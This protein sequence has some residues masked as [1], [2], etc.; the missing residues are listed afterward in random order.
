MCGVFLRVLGIGWLG[1]GGTRS[2]CTVRVIH[3][4]LYFWTNT[5]GM[6]H[7][8][9]TN[10]LAYVNF[11]SYGM[12]RHGDSKWLRTFRKNIVSPSLGSS[13]SCVLIN[14]AARGTFLLNSW[15]SSFHKLLVHYL[16]TPCAEYKVSTNI[17]LRPF[18]E[19]YSF[20]TLYT[21]RPAWLIIIVI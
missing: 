6:T 1:W 8:K 21:V 18:G 15:Q 4:I 19:W 14:T 3:N 2:R 13:T 11:E 12:Y 16:L 20:G 7:L 10:I 5:T 9:I 17:R